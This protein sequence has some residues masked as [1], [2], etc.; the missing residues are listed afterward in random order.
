MREAGVIDNAIFSL[1][2]DLET[3]NSKITFGGYDLE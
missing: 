1:F 3:D 2:M